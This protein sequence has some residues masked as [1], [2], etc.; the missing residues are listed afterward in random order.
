MKREI[1]QLHRRINSTSTS[2]DRVKCEH[3]MAHSLRIKPPTKAKKTKSLEWDEELK[4]NNLILVNGELRKLESWSEESRLELLYST[5]PVPRVRN[6]TKLQ[7]QQRQYR[8][9]MKKAIV[10]ETKKGNQEAAEFLQNVLDTQG[11]VSYSRIDR[12]SKLSMQRKNQRVKMLE[13]YLNAHNQLQRRAPT[14]N[15]YLQEGIF[16]VPHQWQVGS[17]EISLSEYMF[18]TEQFLTDNF[19]EYEIKAI[20]G[21]DD[22]RAKDKKTGHH[23]HYFLSGLNR[24]TQEYDLHKR[25]IQV[26]NEYLEK[27]YAVTNFFSPDSIL[28]KEESADYGH[29]FQKMV[30]DYAN[31]H[32]FHSKGLHVELSPEAERR[33][34]Q[35]KKMNREATLPK[36]EREY[37]YYNYQLEKL[38]ELLKR[39][40]R[41]LAWLDAK[42]EARIDILDDLASQVDL[43]RVDLD[44]LKTAESEIETK[45]ISIKSQYDEYI[46]KVNKLDSVYASHIANI[47]KLIFVRIRAKD[48]NLQNAA[49]DYLNKVKLNL[50]RASPS[51]KLFVSMLA[52]DLNDKDLEVIALDSTNK[53]RSI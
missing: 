46:R 28:S 4:N 14:N 17:D 29:Y 47:C 27:T 6:Q 13:M 53:E 37:N 2:S 7:T 41:R 9:K 44:R 49:L 39:K 45:I 20:I 19:P 5:V 32:L 51:E 12:F 40:E 36:S 50:A 34:E 48:Q 24:E 11:H 18:L 23:P 25:Q 22:E 30:R 21:H 31:E 1:R 43:T 52:K 8:Q 16:K 33:S 3:S 26:V 10:S 38:N 35:R 42:H 15:V